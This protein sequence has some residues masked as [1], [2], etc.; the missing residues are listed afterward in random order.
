MRLTEIRES[1]AIAVD[2]L[3]LHTLRSLLTTLGI[4]I[5][6]LFVSLMGWFLHG[7]D[8]ALERTLEVLGPD[9]LYVDRWDWTGRTS[10]AELRSR[11]HITYWQARLLAEQ[12][13]TAEIVAPMVLASGVRI[14]AGKLS[15]TDIT[16]WG[17]PSNYGR[18][19]HTSLEAGRYFSPAEERSGAPVVVLG[20][21]VARELFPEGNPLG[22]TL[23]IAGHPFTVIGVV[24]K[25]GTFLSQEI[26][27]TIYIPLPAFL[28]LFG[29]ANRSFRIAVK[30]GGEER[31]EQVRDELRMLMRR[32]RN[33]KPTQP[34]D[35]SINEV[36]AL[37]ERIAG[38]RQAVWGV[39]IGMSM[40]SFV[41]GIIGIVNI[42]F[43]SVVERTL[44]IG[45][46]KA[47]GARRSSIALQFLV[48]A[49]LLCAAGSLVALLVGNLVALLLHSSF[50]EAEF[51][52]PY[53]PP[54]H[55]GIALLVA[56]AAGILAGWA[57]A[58]RAARLNPVEA[59]RYE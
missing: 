7:L 6:A 16:I 8:T 45:I 3:R 27:G 39:G 10:W 56:T 21:S 33:L 9:M 5:G 43:V 59:L 19:L 49:I 36:Q 28:R 14:T 25:Q 20:Y 42:M 18:I 32:I 4:A 35:F 40:L 22:K 58:L 57:P 31:K 29:T 13:T 48:E 37:Q 54:Q 2:A 23:R 15:T 46:R 44:E 12:L 41:V 1:I 26:D 51:L 53:I 38:L 55:M 47:V 34:D 11:R 17:T 52:T 50:P 24:A 30:A